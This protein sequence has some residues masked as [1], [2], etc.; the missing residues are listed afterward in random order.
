MDINRQAI[1]EFNGRLQNPRVRTTTTTRTTTSRS[2]QQAR[3][4]PERGE[5]KVKEQ[6][7][8]HRT[9]HAAGSYE[10]GIRH[11]ITQRARKL[12]L[13]KVL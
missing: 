13:I 1:P 5:C 6:E 9:T 2:K 8:E 10:Q 4:N 12:S 7:Q 3:E 11:R